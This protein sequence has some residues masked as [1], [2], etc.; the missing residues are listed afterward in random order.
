[1]LNDKQKGKLIESMIAN[2][3]MRESNGELCASVPL[4]DD[5]GVDIVVNKKG[6]YKVFFAN[7][8][9][10]RTKIKASK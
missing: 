8:K 5:Y 1:M 4:V 6:I 9:L 2:T 10:F 7:Q 3:L